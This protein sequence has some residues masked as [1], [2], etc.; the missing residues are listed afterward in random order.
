MDGT[1]VSHI[2]GWFFTTWAAR[3]AQV[4][5]CSIHI[6]PIFPHWFSCQLQNLK[7]CLSPG[8]KLLPSLHFEDPTFYSISVLRFHPFCLRP[9]S[10]CK[11]LFS[12][13]VLF[14]IRLFQLKLVQPSAHS[15]WNT[16][17]SSRNW[18]AFVPCLWEQ[19]LIN[20][21]YASSAFSPFL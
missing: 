6:K 10:I 15:F 9:F 20:W 16:N 18:L 21:N 13:S 2:T 14:E 3:E 8:S 4:N 11:Y 12:T 17:C 7:I 5:R 19:R 1:H